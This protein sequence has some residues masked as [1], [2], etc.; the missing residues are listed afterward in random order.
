MRQ[1]KDFC[2]ACLA[3]RAIATSR[4]FQIRYAQV[5]FGLVNCFIIPLTLLLK[6]RQRKMNKA[7]RG[8]KDSRQ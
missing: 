6:L 7:V 3:V 5:I 1:L 4:F 2:I 8:I